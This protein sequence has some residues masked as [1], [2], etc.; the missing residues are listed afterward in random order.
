MTEINDNNI[1]CEQKGEHV[2]FDPLISALKLVFSL[3]ISALLL[4][5]YILIL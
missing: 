1:N 4:K 3:S 2:G 5:I